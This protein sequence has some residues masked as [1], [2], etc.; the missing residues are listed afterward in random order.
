METK[1]LIPD[2]LNQQQ[3]LMLRL[4]KTPL[5]EASFTQIRQLAVKLL[6]GQLDIAIEDWEAQNNLAE[7]DYEELSQIHFRSRTK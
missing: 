4:L 7:Q 2:S 6:S 1:E 3:L 5:P